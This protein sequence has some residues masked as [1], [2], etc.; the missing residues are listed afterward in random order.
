MKNSTM[1]III[2]GAA[3]FIG[4]NLSNFLLKKGFQIIGID[5]I[6]DYYDTKVKLQRLNIL[7]KNNKFQFFKYNLENYKKLDLIFKNNSIKCIINLAA[8]AGVRYSIDY[9]KKY[10]NSNIDGF[11]NI[12]ELTKK[13]KIK[14]LIFASSSSVYGDSK[15]FPL[16]EDDSINPKNF[17]GLT[18]KN[19]EEMAK[20]YSNL[21]DLN[22]CGL[23]FFTVYG[24]WGRPD[25]FMMKYLN[26]KKNFNLFN[27][28]EH[29]RDFTYIKDVNVIIYKLIKSSLKGYELFNICNNKPIK[30]T[31]V[32]KL[33]N[34]S[35]IK[36]NLKI[37]K[38]SLQKADVIK[39]H[40]DNSKII[41]KL[42]LIKFTPI[43]IGIKNLINWYKKI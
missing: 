26:S 10:L 21:Y 33:I 43:E 15:K 9:P 25:M 39:T 42:K 6:N 34:K 29:F 14:K 7:K 22:I 13:Y 18:K 31:K 16:K 4:F 41:Q 11:F 23:R 27:K 35:I 2:T 3:G 19:N 38:L 32:I 8:Q 5:N 1:K 36:K 20:I 28:G 24:E 40:G 17:Y 37:N 12:L 30:I